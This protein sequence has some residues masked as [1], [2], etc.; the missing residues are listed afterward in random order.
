MG[1]TGYSFIPYEN[2]TPIIGGISQNSL[3]YNS[4]SRQLG[5]LNDGSGQITT[6][7]E[8]YTDRLNSENAL[9]LINEN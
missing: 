9:Y 6:Y 3:Y 2:T 8:K 5:F 1:G 4:I 7:F